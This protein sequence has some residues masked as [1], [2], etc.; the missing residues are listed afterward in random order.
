MNRA[1]TK[2]WLAAQNIKLPNEPISR[3]VLAAI[4]Q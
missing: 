2:N 3:F 1:A 4:N